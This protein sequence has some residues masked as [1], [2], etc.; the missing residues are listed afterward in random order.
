MGVKALR[1]QWWIRRIKPASIVDGGHARWLADEVVRVVRDQAAKS[2]PAR[3]H[4]FPAA[5]V[6]SLMLLIGEEAQAIGP[7]TVFEF[8]FGDPS[9]KYRRGMSS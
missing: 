3:T 5:P 4:I 9:R 7:T 1:N 2:R 6:T 8:A